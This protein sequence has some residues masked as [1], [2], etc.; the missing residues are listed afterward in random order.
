MSVAEKRLPAP[1]IKGEEDKAADTDFGE[2]WL[3]VN[4]IR[5]EDIAFPLGNK[6]NCLSVC[7]FHFHKL[8]F[9]GE[10]TTIGG[11]TRMET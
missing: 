2:L 11:D 8:R 1:V 5:C 9:K 7:L 6:Q 3:E 10:A 4:L